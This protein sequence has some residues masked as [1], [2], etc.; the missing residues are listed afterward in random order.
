MPL[1]RDEIRHRFGYHPGTSVTVPKHER[2]REAFIAFGEFLD[3]VL[4]DGEAKSKAINELQ[5][6]SMWANFG[7]AETAPLDSIRRYNIITSN[8]SS[9]LTKTET[10]T[11]E[12]NV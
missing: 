7:I 9:G 12:K 3:D 10:P 4:P 5:M 11:S 8:K 1:G 6:S 2:I